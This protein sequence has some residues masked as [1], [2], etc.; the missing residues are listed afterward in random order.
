MSMNE[1]TQDLYNEL[2]ARL[3]DREALRD[4]A[5]RNRDMEAFQYNKD[6]AAALEKAIRAIS[7]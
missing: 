2:S 6:F 3:K 4:T 1:A 7:E 5:Y